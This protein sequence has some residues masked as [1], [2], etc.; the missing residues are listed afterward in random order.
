MKQETLYRKVGRRY[1]PVSDFHTNPAPGV[2]LV[3]KLEYG[4]L[5]KRV[6]MR[7][8]ELPDAVPLIRMERALRD[9]VVEDV[10]NA[11]RDRRWSIHDVIGEVFKSIARLTEA[12]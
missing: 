3:E 2:W 7:V 6:I 5:S 8:G 9:R 11:M 4:G 1:E 12:K 10:L